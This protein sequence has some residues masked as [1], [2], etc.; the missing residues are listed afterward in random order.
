M[1]PINTVGYLTIVQRFGSWASVMG[2]INAELK[3]E[4]SGQ[5]GQ[6][7]AAHPKDES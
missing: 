5:A 4:R 2:R 1:S 3:A 6:E 7:A